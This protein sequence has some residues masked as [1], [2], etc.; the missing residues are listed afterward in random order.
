MA[1]R[2]S[3]LQRRALAICGSVRRRDCFELRAGRGQS[4][5]PA[6]ICVGERAKDDAPRDPAQYG[7][8]CPEI[9]V[10]FGFHSAGNG[11]KGAHLSLLSLAEVY[12][13]G[14]W[15]APFPVH[16]SSK[17]W[18]DCVRATF[19]S[20]RNFGKLLATLAN[21]V[22]TPQ[23]RVSAALRITFR[24][25]PKKTTALSQWCIQPLHV[26]TEVRKPLDKKIPGD[27]AWY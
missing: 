19:Y 7:W 5:P 13:A 27:Y 1:M 17:N 3:D 6:T 22:A 10:T 18:L 12:I 25:N 24:R 15:G 2:A 9:P 21:P 11:L 26:L 14:K 4:A 8:G 23:T 20:D 16:E